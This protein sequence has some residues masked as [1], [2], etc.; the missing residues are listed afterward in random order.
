[1]VDDSYFGINK[2]MLEFMNVKKVWNFYQDVAWYQ[3]GE[4]KPIIIFELQMQETGVFIK[5]LAYNIS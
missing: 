4:A 3:I 5:R 2:K 1:M